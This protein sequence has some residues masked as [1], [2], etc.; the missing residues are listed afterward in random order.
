VQFEATDARRAFPCWDEPA[1]KATFQLVATIP[2]VNERN[3]LAV[4]NTP[5]TE[6]TEFLHDGGR[7]KTYTFAP[8]PKMSTYLLALVVGE[9][10]VVSAFSDK[11]Q[12]Q[13]SVYT[14]PGKGSKGK[15]CLSTALEALDFFI[16]FY[17][18]KYPLPKSDL[19]AIPDF[20][21]GAM[22]N[23]G[24]VT[25]REAKILTDVGTSLQMKKGIARTVCHELAHQWFGNLTTMEWWDGLFLNEGFAR[26]MEFKA[27]DHIFPQWD[28]WNE[29]IQ[30]V[31]AMA[32]GLDAMMTSHPV[33]MKCNSPDEIDSMFDSISYAKGASML[34]MVSTYLGD[35]VFMKGIRLY[36]NQ[37]AYSNTIPTDLWTCLSTA[38]GVDVNSFLHPWITQVGFPVITIDD[39]A[40]TVTME[41]FLASGRE[42]PTSDSPPP[43]AWPCAFGDLVLDVNDP[44]SMKS[45]L[46]KIAD[47]KKA[48]PYFILNS[49]RSGF[50][51]INYSPANWAAL[52]P[53]LQPGVLPSID[54]IALIDDCFS[55]G[56]AGYI[57]VTT[58]LDLISSF[59]DFGV[60]DFIVWQEVSEQL[61]GLAGFYKNEPFFPIFQQFLLK[62]ASKQAARLGWEKKEGEPENYGS[63]RNAV[64]AMMG[65]AGDPATLEYCAKRFNVYA[66]GG[67]SVSADLRKLVYKLALKQDEEGVTKTLL[68]L[69]RNTSFPGESAREGREDGSVMIH[70]VPLLNYSLLRAN[71]VT[72]GPPPKK[73][74]F[75]F[76]H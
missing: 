76:P 42:L 75:L 66:A 25:Y 74:P 28:I 47:L 69:Y 72:R 22:E 36:L 4:S 56:K 33:E 24:C 23:W 65:A 67:E 20:A 73:R 13:T 52:A 48:S 10:D 17:G 7:Y 59:G 15:F 45:L 54:R 57:S 21:A 9:F 68:R 37:Y 49:G 64:H 63:F 6:T 2:L 43:P 70:K 44:A 3:M 58:A 14:M 61:L 16:D 5:V 8:T 53:A 55:L 60:D 18:V 40:G 11:N 50:F 27:V 34:R 41:R 35:D 39:V 19:L 62:I 12:I 26:F 31:Y 46:S 71:C 1:F 38:S 32:M 51:R 30:S 29:F